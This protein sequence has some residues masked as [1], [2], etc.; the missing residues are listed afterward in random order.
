MSRA[1]NNLLATSRISSPVRKGDVSM[2]AKNVRLS[3]KSRQKLVEGIN[4][5]ANAVKVTLG[6]KVGSARAW[7]RTTGRA[8]LPGRSRS[9]SQTVGVLTLSRAANSFQG[10]NVVLERKYGVPEIVNDGVTIA[11]D[12]ELADP[13]QNV[14][15]KLVQVGRSVRGSR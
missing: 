7:R 10:R 15:V 12:I 13:E 1:G 9:C 5:V 4:I 2:M 6:P 8:V 11:R 3:E 14:G